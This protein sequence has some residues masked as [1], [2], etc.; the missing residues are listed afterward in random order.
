MSIDRKKLVTDLGTAIFGV[1][2]TLKWEDDTDVSDTVIAV[3]ETATLVVGSFLDS[4]TEKHPERE[5]KLREG[6]RL[7]TGMFTTKMRD[8]IDAALRPDP[9]PEKET[10]Q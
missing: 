5:K 7:V 6:Q 4:L 8:V 9:E 1:I 3:T 10:A 2:D